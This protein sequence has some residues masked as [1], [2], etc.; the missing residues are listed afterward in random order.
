MNVNSHFVTMGYPL[1]YTGLFPYVSHYLNRIQNWSEAFLPDFVQIQSS[2][3]INV[4]D[5]SGN[6]LLTKPDE[7]KTVIA[8]KEERWSYYRTCNFKK[9]L[10]KK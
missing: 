5:F 3:G 1:M 2:D 7:L 4:G 9:P 10:G 8:L 6:D